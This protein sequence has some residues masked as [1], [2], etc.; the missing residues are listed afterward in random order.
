MFHYMFNLNTMIIHS[1]TPHKLHIHTNQD[2]DSEEIEF[3]FTDSLDIYHLNC[4][5]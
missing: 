1:I 4:E 5:I 2:T 3:L